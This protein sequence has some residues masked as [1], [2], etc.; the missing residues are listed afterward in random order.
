MF[1]KINFICP[2]GSL[3]IEHAQNAKELNQN[4]P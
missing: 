4:R 1:I 2:D 3:E